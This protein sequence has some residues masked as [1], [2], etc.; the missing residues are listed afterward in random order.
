[1]ADVDFGAAVGGALEAGAV[2]V[3]L[4]GRIGRIEYLAD[5]VA[6]EVL[7]D[8]RAVFRPVCFHH[9]G[10]RRFG[11]DG[12]TGIIPKLLELRPQ[13]FRRLLDDQPA[14]V[15]VALDLDSGVAGHA[16]RITAGGRHRG[17]VPG[18]LL[19]RGGGDAA[20]VRHGVA[21]VFLQLGQVRRHV[22][23]RRLLGRAVVQSVGLHHRAQHTAAT[24]A[25]HER[26]KDEAAGGGRGNCLANS[27][28][29]TG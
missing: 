3:A 26:G 9:A 18:L 6:D 7:R 16:D 10:G 28:V 2:L 21:V 4:A 24:K 27:H 25:D 1:M 20:P 12:E 19:A 8:L 22:Q 29:V 23:R 14:L 17:D 5:R 13:L 15:A 11:F